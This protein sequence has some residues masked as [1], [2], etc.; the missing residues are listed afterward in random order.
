MTAGAPGPIGST[1]MAEARRK[2]GIA[3]LEA[4][5]AVIRPRLEANAEVLARQGLAGCERTPVAAASGWFGT[6]SG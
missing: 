5:W 3:G 2:P 6:S 1:A 4:R